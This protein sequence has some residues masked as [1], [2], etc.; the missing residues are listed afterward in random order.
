MPPE[1]VHSR[2][3]PSKRCSSHTTAVGRP[4]YLDG[5]ESIQ[6]DDDISEVRALLDEKSELHIPT[7]LRDNISVAISQVSPT[8]PSSATTAEAVAPAAQQSGFRSRSPECP[9][10]K[11][12]HSHRHTHIHYRSPDA[13]DIGTLGS[14]LVTQKELSRSKTCSPAPQA[15]FAT[16]TARRAYVRQRAASAGIS[17]FRTNRATQVLCLA[18]LPLCLCLQGC[19]YCVLGNQGCSSAHQRCSDGM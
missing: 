7:D 4:N 5:P 16:R 3:R 11:V 13:H 15:Q 12:R 10:S 14:P 19:E 1:G 2:F 18:T 6:L 17:A 9:H 8:T